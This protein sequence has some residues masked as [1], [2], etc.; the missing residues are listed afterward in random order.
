LLLRSIE[1]FLS[2]HVQPTAQDTGRASY[3]SGPTQS[4]AQFSW[5]WPAQRIYDLIRGFAPWPG[6]QCRLDG[7]PV[8]IV[9][10]SIVN[11]AASAPPGTILS[12]PN[13]G[14]AHVATADRVLLVHE[15]CGSDADSLVRPQSR[16][17]FTE[18]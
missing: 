1:E 13:P 9:R 7:Q 2:G 18:A 17:R 12:I 6:G 15:V 5:N 4:D 14:E 8:R 10:A 3:F 16:Q 11:D